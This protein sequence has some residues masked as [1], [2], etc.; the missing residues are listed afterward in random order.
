MS[1]TIFFWTFIAAI[2][3]IDLTV[4]HIIVLTDL[5]GIGEEQVNF[6]MFDYLRK[7]KKLYDSHQQPW[8]AMLNFGEAHEDSMSV[9]GMFCCYRN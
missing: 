4:V 2:D 7:F 5:V 8:A 6:Y 3:T 1:R 9:G